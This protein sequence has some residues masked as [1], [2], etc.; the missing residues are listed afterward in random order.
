MAISVR[1]ASVMHVENDSLRTQ[2]LRMAKEDL[3]DQN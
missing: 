2:S 3:G 1:K